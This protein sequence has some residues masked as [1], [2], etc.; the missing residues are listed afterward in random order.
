MIVSAS[1]IISILTN[2]ASLH[3]NPICDVTDLS[4]RARTSWCS[5]AGGRYTPIG[6]VAHPFVCVVLIDVD[7]GNY[8]WPPSLSMKS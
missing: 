8:N 3:F 7:H 5:T 4:L 2:I 1:A 6:Y